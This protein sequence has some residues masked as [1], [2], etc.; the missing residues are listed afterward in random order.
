MDE[1]GRPALWCVLAI[2]SGA[3]AMQGGAAA[4]QEPAGQGPASPVKGE[5]T[6]TIPEVR[7]RAQPVQAPPAQ[8]GEKDF[9]ISEST[10]GARM[11]MLQKEIPQSIQVVPQK[12]I[13]DQ[14]ILFPNEALRNISG[15]AAAQPVYSEFQRYKIRG[16]DVTNFYKDGMLDISFDRTYWLGNV[17]RVEVL[18][19]PAS[20]L[21][22]SADPGGLINYISRRPLAEPTFTAL[23][24][25][26]NFNWV[27]TLLDVSG[28]VTKD[29]SAT[30]RII[31]NFQDSDTFSDRFHN[32]GKFLSGVTDIR[33]GANTTLTV[34]AE[35]R[36]RIQD[37]FG[38][39]GLPAFG[40]VIGPVGSLPISRNFN[41]SYAIRQNLGALV[42]VELEHRFNNMWSFKSWLRW[43]HIN[44]G[45]NRIV[46]RLA[47]DNQTLNRDF[48]VTNSY[49]EDY[50]TNNTAVAKFETLGIRHQLLLGLEL[51]VQPTS[52]RNQNGNLASI[53]I[54]N[55]VF[56]AQPTNITL[57]NEQ[58]FDSNTVGPYIQDLIEILPNLKL[59]LGGRY[60]YVDR[61]LSDPVAGVHTSRQ[62]TRFSPRVGLVYEPLEGVAL[63]AGYSTSFLPISDI[64]AIRTRGQLFDPEIGKQYEGG[65]KLDL[66][67]RLTATVAGY[68]LTREN[69]LTINPT[70]PTQ[71]IAVGKQ[72]S[73]GAEVDL[74]YKLTEGWNVLIAYAYTDAEVTADNAIRV[75][76]RPSNVPMNS[77]R[78]WSSYN[79]PA[80]PLA[81]LMVGAGLFAAGQR[82]GDANNSFTLPSYATVDASASYPWNRYRASLRINNL[83]NKTYFEAADSRSSVFPGVPFT[84]LGTITATF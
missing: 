28:P 68:Q 57:R 3:Y 60:D 6:V 76:N 5:P 77:A 70:D 40:T 1:I 8:E 39:V 7:V 48:F 17:D 41:E 82:Y 54:F 79:V 50:R 21:Y 49:T 63:Y 64:T 55:P 74:T 2:L 45:Q 43:T 83:L 9:Y 14:R 31:G 15:V 24:S 73:R 53:N 81:G 20:V 52:Y 61:Q 75:G 27:E 34:R 80:G 18:K 19:G 78:L 44:Y 36:Q 37:Q 26:G 16:F 11:P 29:K 66:S 71:S 22:G 65:V 58:S 59:M 62:D 32:S 35:I 56:G 12:I 69:V 4:A 33:L 25:L 67:R 47:A 23:A 46:P 72:R 42:G 84:V 38:R 51:A 10:T 30:Y 13:Q